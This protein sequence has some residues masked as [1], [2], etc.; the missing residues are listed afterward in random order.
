[1][2]KIALP[3]LVLILS[4]IVIWQFRQLRRLSPPDDYEYAFRQDID[5]DYHNPR[6]VADYYETGYSIGTFAREAWRTHGID[7]RH[8]DGDWALSRNA[9]QRYDRLRAVADTMGMRLARS[10]AF[11]KQGLNNEDI[12]T[13]EARGAT[14]EQVR[15][16]KHFH[17]TQIL[18]G[19]KSPAVTVL[20]GKLLAKGYTIPHDG[21]YWTETEQAVM[22][23]QQKNKLAA[24]GVADLETLHLLIAQ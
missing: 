24:T 1:M 14:A 13:I 5:M 3:V 17:A 4:I 2:K 22:D 11:K 9:G 16:Q 10:L 8:P 23:F 6:L 19:D 21:Y 12:R 18:R 7:V 20:Q 15:V